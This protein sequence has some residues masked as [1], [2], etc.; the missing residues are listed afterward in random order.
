MSSDGPR[1]R[2]RM[3][4]AGQSAASHVRE[5]FITGIAVMVPILI[6]FYVLHAALGL[7]TNV[8]DPLAYGLQRL[9]VAPERRFVI[10][11]LTAAF[12]LVALTFSVGFF[13]SF[14][15]GERALE[16]FDLLMERIPG[17]GSVYASFRQM[18]DVMLESDAENFRK[19]VLVEYPHEGAY[20]LGFE[21]VRTPEPI[22]DAA[23]DESLRTLFLPLAPNPVMGG[24]LAH[25]PESRIMDVDMTVEEGM[26]TVIT[27]GVAVADTAE[28][29]GL[30][31]AQLEELGGA[32][33][34]ERFVDDETEEEER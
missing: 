2:R 9:D 16:Y 14:Q 19:V 26:R 33:V 10:V 13:A 25:V 20:T 17:I 18:S 32:E 7:F 6:T 30:S 29:E 15:S 11:Q 27:T 5:A 23:G 12:L 28:A 8:L 1:T 34:G 24:F 4:A 3:Q 21:T 31:R 22:R